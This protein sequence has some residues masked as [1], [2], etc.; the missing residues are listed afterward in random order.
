MWD[1]MI[2]YG[3]WFFLSDL[4]HLAQCPQSPSMLLQMAGVLSSSFIWLNNSP[5]YVC[6]CMCCS[7]IS[8]SLPPYGWIVTLQ[9]PLP[10]GFSQQEFWCG[11][12]FPSPE[13][14]PDP[15]IEPMS[16]ML[17]ADF[18][19]LSHWRNPLVHYMYVA[20]QSLSHVWHFVTPW[21]TA[22]QA[23]LSLTISRSLL[24]VMSI[25]SVMPS[26]YLILCRPLLLPTSIFPSI[27]V[28]SNKL[29]IFIRWPK[30]WGFS[31]SISPSN[32]YSELIFFRIYWFD[33]LAVQG[34][35]KSL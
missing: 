18:F 3:I 23:S 21:T 24:K 12:P 6:M 7:V 2:S 16:P 29:A 27:R 5:L 32:E 22:C 30:Y 28:F 4:F 17:Q 20:V 10:I 15:E 25:E 33:L 9:A 11:L 26:N 34:T 13:G 35:L 31:L 1:H 14:L 8:N 19:L